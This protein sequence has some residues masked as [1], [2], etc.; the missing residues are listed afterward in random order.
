[1]RILFV[2]VLV[3]SVVVSAN[4][5]ELG[6]GKLDAGRNTSGL[7]RSTL[8]EAHYDGF[9][10]SGA[11]GLKLGLG[12]ANADWDLGPASGSE[13]LFA[14][15]ISLFYKTT[16]SLDVNFSTTFLSAEDKDVQLGRTEADVVRLAL[17]VRYWVNTQTRTTPFVGAGIGYYLL[18]GMTENTREDGVVVP[19]EV[20]VKDAPGA[21]IEG[22]AAFQISDNF[23]LTTD[24]T[25]DFLLGSAD[26]QI[27]G[28]DSSFD[29]TSFAIN[30]GMMWTF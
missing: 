3:M 17:G 25:Y 2:V 5:Q 22:G 16:E 24:L 20:S 12:W 30:V 4:A 27:N 18:D 23:F 28:D 21:F 6:R 7:G 29:L 13:N 26:A 10:A 14:P 19:A 9:S 11:W 15:Q 8:P 1:M